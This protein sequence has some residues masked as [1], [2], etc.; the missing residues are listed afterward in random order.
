MTAR[1]QLTNKRGRFCG[2]FGLTRS[3][4]ES[5]IITSQAYSGSADF[6]VNENDTK[7]VHKRRFFKRRCR[8][9]KLQQGLPF[10]R[11]SV[12]PI[13]IDLAQNGLNRLSNQIANK[14]R[15]AFYINDP[16]GHRSIL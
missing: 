7:T 11:K 6:F 13:I 1:I 4:Y 8:F 14:K 16:T 5:A 10:K 9:L 3:V 2:S 15:L 12:R